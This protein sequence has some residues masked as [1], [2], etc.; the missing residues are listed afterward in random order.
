MISKVIVIFSTSQHRSY[1]Q[2]LW[3]YGHFWLFKA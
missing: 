1:S 2:R 3:C